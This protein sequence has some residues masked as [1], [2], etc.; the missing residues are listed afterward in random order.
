M[1]SFAV[2]VIQRLDAACLPDS[3]RDLN[4]EVAHAEGGFLLACEGIRRRAAFNVHG[5]V[6][7]ERDAV[8]ARHG[9]QAHF[10]LRHVERL[11]CGVGHAPANFEGVPNRLAV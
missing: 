11:L 1:R 5:A 6:L 9:L 8:G 10:E 3:C 2:E 7:D 4:A